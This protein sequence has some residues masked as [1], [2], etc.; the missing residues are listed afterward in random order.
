[1]D[2]RIITMNLE[3]VIAERLTEEPVV[4]LSDFSDG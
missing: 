3:A 4:I 1:M 2:K